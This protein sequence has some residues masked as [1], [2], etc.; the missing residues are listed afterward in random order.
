MESNSLTGIE[1]ELVLQYLIDGNVPVTVTPVDETLE[2]ESVDNQ[3]KSDKKDSDSKEEIKPAL[4]AVFPIAL[5][6]EQIKVLEQ[7]IILLT[8]PPKSVQNFTTKK[9]RVE[10]YFNRLGLYFLTELKQVKAGL[11]L[12]IPSEI[13]RITELESERPL[14]FSATLFYSCSE[15]TDVHIDCYPVQNY[16]L[17]SKPI[18]ADVPEEIQHKAKD[19]LEEFIAH[20]RKTGTAGNGVQLIPVCRYLADARPK[21]LEVEGRANPLDIIFADYERIVFAS[22]A[23]NMHLESGA[24]YALEMSFPIES[25]VIKVRKMFLTCGVE[26]LY[27]NEEKTFTAAVCRYTSIKEEDVRFLYEKTTNKIFS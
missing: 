8:N 6:G 10:F 24:E 7:G 11:A 2:V 19:Y 17:F 20:A 3:K 25:T 1:R 21:I 27:Q 23:D 5:K 12:V 13:M 18:W 14:D 15:N 22:N 4:S 16:R 9:V 26:A